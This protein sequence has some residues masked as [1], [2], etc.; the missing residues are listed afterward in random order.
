MPP[1]KA[2][3]W[4]DV[5]NFHCHTLVSCCVFGHNPAAGLLHLPVPLRGF[6]VRHHYSPGERDRGQR[7]HEE[8][9]PGWHSGDLP[10][11]PSRVSS[12]CSAALF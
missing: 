2:S 4:P 9:G 5:F 11:N 6:P 1:R 3:G 10:C 7:H 12:K 8:K